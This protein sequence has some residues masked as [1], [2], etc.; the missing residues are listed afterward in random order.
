MSW[1]AFVCESAAHAI[2]DFGKCE[3]LYGTGVDQALHL[4]CKI[5]WLALFLAP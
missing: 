1:E 3:K 2:I 5:L 4:A